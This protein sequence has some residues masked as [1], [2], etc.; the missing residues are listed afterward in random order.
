MLGQRLV[1]LGTSLMR[2]VAAQLDCIGVAGLAA[3]LFSYR[4]S[5]WINKVLSCGHV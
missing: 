1:A 4:L 5:G 3:A 2:L